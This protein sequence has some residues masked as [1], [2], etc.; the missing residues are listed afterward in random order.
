MNKNIK[1]YCELIPTASDKYGQK[2][3]DYSDTIE[4]N[5]Q[6]TDTTRQNN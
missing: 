1:N 5:L 6:T 2:T 4:Y 3:T